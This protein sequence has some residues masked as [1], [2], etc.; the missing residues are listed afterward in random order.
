MENFP[1]SNELLKQA[2]I[3]NFF[4]QTCSFEDVC[5]LA[6]KLSSYVSFSKNQMNEMKQEFMLLQTI[7]LDNFEDYVKEE[8]AIRTDQTGE[9]V[10]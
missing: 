1:L 9:A 8:T 4:H 7:G 2:Q 3:L 6:N 5:A 10:R